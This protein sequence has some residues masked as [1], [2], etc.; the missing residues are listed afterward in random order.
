MRVYIGCFG[1]GLGHA[2]RML[3]IADLLSQRGSHVRFSSSGEVASYIEERGYACNR[4]PLA[5]VTYS[6]EGEL[7]MRRTM[8]NSPLILARTYRQ[9]WMEL[10]NM[11]RFG[12]DVVLSDSVVSTVVAARMLNV[13]TY[14]VLNQLNLAAPATRM[15]TPSLLL[16]EGT[17]AGMAKL[18]GLSDRILLP[19]LPPPYT[20]SESNLRGGNVKNAEFVGFITDSPINAPDGTAAEFASDRRPKVLWQISGPPRTRGPLIK[21]AREITSA[22][23][24]EYAFVLAEGDPKGSRAA[25]RV[26]GGWEYGWCDISQFYYGACDFVVSRAGHGAVAQAITNSKPSLL[27]PIPRQTE[28][29]GNAAKAAR[30]GVSISIRQDELSQ[31]S[32]RSAA[33]ALMSE[34]YLSQAAEVGRIARSYDARMAIVRM[35]EAAVPSGRPR[36]H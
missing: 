32:F 35:V 23:A 17:T 25:R 16:S 26:G 29:E 31:E 36:L 9:L 12:P 21:K 5:D 34:P 24:S 27:I 6:E 1:S 30:L 28:Q 14:T 15:G 22:F 2:T 11:K 8:A 33:K 10:A 20:I 4:L 18:W 19:D 3:S 13:R 7:S